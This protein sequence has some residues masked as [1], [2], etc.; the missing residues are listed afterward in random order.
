M[1]QSLWCEYDLHG[2][3]LYS[4]KWYKDQ[5]EFY[6]FTITDHDMALKIK[7]P[8]SFPVELGMSGMRVVHLTNISLASAG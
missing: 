8:G 3:P 1:N 6:R 2:E 5:Q 7:I 4:I